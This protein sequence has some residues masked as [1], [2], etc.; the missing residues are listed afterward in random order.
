MS[1]RKVLQR[2]KG[3]TLIELLVV[4][5]IIAIL[6]ALLVP[7]VQKVRE[8]AART[9]STNNL[10][11]IGLAFHGFHDANK[12]LPWNGITTRV[13][14]TTTLPAYGGNALAGDNTSGSWAFQILPYID[15]NPIFQP[16]GVAAGAAV[17]TAGGGIAAYMCPGRG[18]PAIAGAT[19]WSDYAINPY[20]NSPT[21]GAVSSVNNKPTM[22]GIQDGTSNTIFVGHGR[23]PQNIYQVATV[24]ATYSNS[25]FA[26]GTA[27][28]CRSMANAAQVLQRDPSAANVPGPAAAGGQWGA[29]FP[30]G[31]MMAMGDATVRMFP[32][33]LT[34]GTVASTGA[35][36][37]NTLSA[38]LTPTGGESATIP[39]A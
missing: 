3:F 8:A 7:A 1:F 9:Q 36:A 38:F 30:Q 4:I 2:N 6:I 21:N 28:T 17:T 39:D 20:I 25:I 10:K 22:V 23:M 12:R 31:A 13:A 35:G 19:P 37:N 11:N 27:G 16:T 29:P 34:P 32:Y 26:A 5:A 14:A 24:N 15:Q 33:S 18:R